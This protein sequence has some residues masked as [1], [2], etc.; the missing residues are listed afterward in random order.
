MRCRHGFEIV[1][2][3]LKTFSVPIVKSKSLLLTIITYFL[4]LNLCPL[5]KNQF[6]YD[7]HLRRRY[8]SS[9]G[10]CNPGQGI[11]QGIERSGKAGQGKKSLISTFPCFLTATAK[12]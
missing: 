8:V 5:K 6:F 3:K 7:D 11:W 9:L 12:V 10:T 1:G 4:I 2:F